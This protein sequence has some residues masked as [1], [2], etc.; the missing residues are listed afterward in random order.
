MSAKSLGPRVTLQRT[1]QPAKPR[2]HR[3]PCVCC[4]QPA[5]PAPDYYLIRGE[6]PN[7]R[8]ASLHRCEK[9]WFKLENSCRLLKNIR[10]SL[11]DE[12]SR[13]SLRITNATRNIRTYLHAPILLAHRSATRTKAKRHLDSS[14]AQRP[15]IFILVVRHV[16]CWMRWWLLGGW[17]KKKKCHPRPQ[18]NAPRSRRSLR[19]HLSTRRKRLLVAVDS[20]PGSLSSSHDKHHRLSI[21]RYTAL[22]EA[23]KSWIAPVTTFAETSATAVHAAI[24]AVKAANPR[25]VVWSQGE[26]TQL[27]NFKQNSN[28]SYLQGTEG[29]PYAAGAAKP[30]SHR[31]PPRLLCSACAPPTTKSSAAAVGARPRAQSAEARLAA[32][33]RAAAQRTPRCSPKAAGEP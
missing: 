32:G 26:Q 1:E 25:A 30:R 3:G 23:F 16:R 22:E 5:A 8:I 13:R 14:G 19:A 11:L 9:F 33:A 15:I 28:N 24:A 12:N 21:T 10:Q 29:S 4:A 18:R 2:S 27:Q 20:N 7:G 6:T 17:K 31:S